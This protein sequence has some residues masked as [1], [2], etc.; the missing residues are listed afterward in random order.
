MINLSGLSP[1][2]DENPEGDIKIVFTGLRA[3]ENYMRNC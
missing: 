1:I 2:T 3:G